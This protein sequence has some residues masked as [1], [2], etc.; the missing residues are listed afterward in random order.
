MSDRTNPEVIAERQAQNRHAREVIAGNA[1]QLSHRPSTVV[2][3]TSQR[4]TQSSRP[5]P[6]V[7]TPAQLSYALALVAILLT[8]VALYAVLDFT[9]ASVALFILSLVLM[10]GWFVFST[11]QSPGA[12]GQ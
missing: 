2:T 1:V 8:S 7:A 12:R 3:A 9:A 5:L 4:S 6:T 10:A 11:S